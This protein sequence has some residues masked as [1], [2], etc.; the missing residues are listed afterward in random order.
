LLG[1][2]LS[3]LS[4]VGVLLGLHLGSQLLDLSL[5]GVLG[6]LGSGL[7]LDLGLLGLLGV[8]SFQLAPLDMQLV[9]NSS[10]LFCLLLGLGLQFLP[11]EP[12]KVFKHWVGRR[13]GHWKPEVNMGVGC[14]ADVRERERERLII[15]IFIKQWGGDT[16]LVVVQCFFFWSGHQRPLRMS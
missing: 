10:G 13:V 9:L 1:L 16:F 3:E 15:T 12:N 4:L 6:L 5:V 7:P 2:Q 14:G 8:L 11:T